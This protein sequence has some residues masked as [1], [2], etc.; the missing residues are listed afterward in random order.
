MWGPVRTLGCIVVSRSPLV[1]S[2][3]TV[4]SFGLRDAYA[5]AKIPIERSVMSTCFRT[6]VYAPRGTDFIENRVITDGE[7]AAKGKR[8]QLGNFTFHIVEHCK[9]APCNLLKCYEVGIGSA[10]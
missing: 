2:R 5:P 1:P 9:R 8:V 3:C 6:P 10:V 4:A 7:R